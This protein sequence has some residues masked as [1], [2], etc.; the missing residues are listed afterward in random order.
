MNESLL[1]VLLAKAKGYTVE[2][3]TSEYVIEP[4]GSKRLVKEKV[5]TKHYPP[6]NTALKSYIE[7]CEGEGKYDNYTDEQLEAERVRLIAQL[8]NKEA[9]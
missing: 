5:Q 1:K 2:E 6:D 3:V 4:D 7:N 9:K 8:N